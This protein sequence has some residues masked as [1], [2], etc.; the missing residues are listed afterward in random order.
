MG[1]I[2][3]SKRLLKIADYVPKG[4]SVADIGSDHALLPS[5]LISKEIAPFVIAGELNEGP[6][7]AAKKQISEL[8]IDNKVSVRE[9]DGLSVIMREKIDVVTIAGMGGTLITEILEKGKEHLK[10]VERLILQPNVGEK[11]VRKWLD[12]NGWNLISEEIIEEDNIIYE[13]I[14][15]VKRQSETDP[16]YENLALSKEKLYNIGPIL[17][18]K[19]S[20]LTIKKWK[21]ELEKK[22]FILNQLD[23]SKLLTEKK[24]KKEQ[25]MAEIKMI[26]EVLF[27]LE[28]DKI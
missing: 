5:Y 17:F 16:V 27:W 4:K 1:I 24:I 20:D 23:K 9:G 25:V 28:K 2:N 26:K 11:P 15:A 8:N 6:Y 7:Q 14:V 19:K 12:K 13:I 18:M 3:L 21:Q 10:T 22:K